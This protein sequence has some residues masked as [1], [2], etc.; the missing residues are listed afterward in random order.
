MP[1]LLRTLEPLVWLRIP[2]HPASHG[3]MYCH[4]L[5]IRTDW[6]PTFLKGE[7]YITLEESELWGCKK[8]KWALQHA[9]LLQYILC[10]TRSQ[11]WEVID[12]LL[13]NGHL[14]LITTGICLF[15][16]CHIH[17]LRSKKKKK[18]NTNEMCRCFCLCFGIHKAL[19][20][21][22]GF[23]QEDIPGTHFSI[24]LKKKKTPNKQTKHPLPRTYTHPHT[25]KAKETR[26]AS[27][28][29]FESRFRSGSYTAQERFG[30]QSQ[31]QGDSQKRQR[32]TSASLTQLS[33]DCQK[34]AKE[35]TD[36]FTSS[37]QPDI[38]WTNH[39]LTTN[40]AWCLRSQWVHAHD[41]SKNTLF[42]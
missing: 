19:L 10:V 37:P 25:E 4:Q 20:L 9:S 1:R 33:W 31:S 6:T 32:G 12:L 7:N 18:K 21:Y 28:H 34:R 8:L 24:N 41:E 40:T 3:E 16:N 13:I 42:C 14:E 30:K 35:V 26:P 15:S 29:P 38:A 27:I 2:Q 22:P 23:R 39:P 5:K 11:E 17:N 36:Q